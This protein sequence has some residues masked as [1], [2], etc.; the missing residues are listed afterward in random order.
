LG[1]LSLL[2]II[3]L[4]TLEQLSL[5][6]FLCSDDFKTSPPGAVMNPPPALYIGIAG[7]RVGFAERAGN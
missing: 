1:A 2:I 5:L 3:A 6:I 7:K 4:G